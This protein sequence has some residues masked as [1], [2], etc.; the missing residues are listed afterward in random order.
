MVLP[1]T[2][3]NEKCNER[4]RGSEMDTAPGGSLIAMKKSEEPFG[5]VIVPNYGC[6]VEA[7]ERGEGERVG[8]TRPHVCRHTN[9]AGYLRHESATNKGISK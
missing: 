9:D 1:S 2:T 7:E 8:S 6:K 3:R 4:Y 5:C